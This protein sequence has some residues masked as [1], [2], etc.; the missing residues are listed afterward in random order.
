MQLSPENL[1]YQT[2]KVLQAEEKLNQKE[3]WIYKNEIRE[4]MLATL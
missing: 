4:V 1:Y 2:V 3:I